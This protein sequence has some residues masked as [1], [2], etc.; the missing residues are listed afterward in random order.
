MISRN[1]LNQKFQTLMDDLSSMVAENRVVAKDKLGDFI[2]HGLP[3]V[4]SDAVIATLNGL[5]GDYLVQRDSRF[6]MEMAFRDQ[7]QTLSLDVDKLNQ[8]LPACSDRIVLCVHG[9]CMNDVQWKRKEHDHGRSLEKFGYTPVYLRYNTGQH[10][11]VNGEQFSLMLDQLISSWPCKVKELVIIG[12]SMGGLVTRSA[13]YYAQQHQ[14]N[15]LSVLRT[16]VTL[17][18]P[19]NGAPLAQLAC[20]IDDR[21]AEA[22]YLKM[23]NKLSDIRSSGTKDLSKGFIRHSD[24]ETKVNSVSDEPSRPLLPDGVVCCAIASCLGQNLDDDKNLKLG[25][26]LVPVSSA[27]GESTCEQEALNYQKENTWVGVGINHL[28]LLTHPQVTGKLE[29]WVLGNTFDEPDVLT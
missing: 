21:V 17:G 5:L 1:N 6:K 13:C 23:L 24:W 22:P 28:D 16:F 29:Q 18:T 27:L 12:H 4:Q 7:Q 25:D 8:Q 3:P 20:W 10:I 19:H 14:L 15:W 9:W 11:S 26:G 2:E